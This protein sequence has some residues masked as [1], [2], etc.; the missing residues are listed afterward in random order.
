MGVDFSN[1][2]MRGKQERLI[3]AVFVLHKFRGGIDRGFLLCYN[4]PEQGGE[5]ALN[6]ISYAAIAVVVIAAVRY[7]W[8]LKQQK[9]K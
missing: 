6:L 2:F 8:Y 9:K 5:G 1:F 4:I 7:V 3:P